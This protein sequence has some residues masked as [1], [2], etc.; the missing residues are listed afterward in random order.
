MFQHSRIQSFG[1]AIDGGRQSRRA[2][3]H[4]HQVVNRSLQRLPDPDRV[5]QLPVRGIAQQQQRP[6]RNHRR[7]GFR[8]SELLEQLVHIRVGLQI[9]P[10]KQNPILRQEIA[11]P[12]RVRR[13][14]RADHAQPRVVGRLAQQLPPRDER[15]QDDI[16]GRRALVQDAPQRIP[17][18]LVYLGIAPGNCVDDG[19]QARHVRDIAREL[20]RVMDHDRL[21]LV[22]R[23]IDNLHL[24]RFH[25]EEAEVWSPTEKSFCPS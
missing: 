7:I 20:A 15:L 25:D 3:A 18:N 5:R 23:V 10:R 14:S 13:V 6:E 19:R 24:P 12:E 1:S 9:D 8:H 17:G 16:A 21:W 22:A 11:H 4:H 2:G